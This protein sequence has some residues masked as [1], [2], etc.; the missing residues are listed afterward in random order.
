MKQV[1]K[2]LYEWIIRLAN[3]GIDTGNLGLMVWCC[4]V[5]E[6]SECRIGSFS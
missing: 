2:P 4:W 5:K 6:F 3:A 1:D